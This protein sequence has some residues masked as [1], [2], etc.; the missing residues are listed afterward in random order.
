[1][2]TPLEIQKIE[3]KKTVGGY[4]RADVDEIFMVL[5][6]DYEAI[7]KENIRLKDKIEVL[8]GLVNNYKGMEDTMRNTL[9][10]AQKAADDLSKS[11]EQKAAGIIAKAERESELIREAARAQAAETIKANEET[12]REILSYSIQVNSILDTQKKLI[13]KI[14]ELRSDNDGLRSDT[15]SAENGLPDEGVASAERT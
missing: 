6:G 10:V 9:V 15:E 14:L 4:R 8:E 1:M 5:S 12:K 2:L 13:E 11:A 3:F 7:Y